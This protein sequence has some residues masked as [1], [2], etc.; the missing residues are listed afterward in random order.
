[1]RL[2]PAD[3]EAIALR[4]AEILAE[5]G[6]VAPA[7][8]RL[9][10]AAEAAARIGMSRDFVYEHADELGAIRLGEGSRPRLAFDPRRLDEW[11]SA[12]SGG[13]RSDDREP[14]PGP[15]RRRRAQPDAGSAVD[16][17]PIARENGRRLTG[18]NGPGGARTPRGPATKE[19]P[20]PRSQRSP[21]GCRASARRTSLDVDD[22]RRP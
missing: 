18:K 4:T 8:P 17:L 5:R 9:F 6:L 13:G 20:S 11:V 22:E 15:A 7:A 21:R 10:S 12:R 1:V 2:D 16:L 14:A 3:V 19:A